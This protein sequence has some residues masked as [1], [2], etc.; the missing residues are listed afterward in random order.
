MIRPGVTV[1]LCRSGQGGESFVLCRSEDR[2]VKEAAIHERFSKRIEDRLESLEKRLRKAKKAADRDKVAVQIGRILGQNSRAA[3]KYKVRIRED[4]GR[5]SG[6]AV[7]WTTKSDWTEWASLT[8]GMY[9]LRTSL[10]PSEW[11]AEDLWTSY[12]QLTDAEAA[13]RTHKHDLA[14]RPV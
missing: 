1:K 10:D 9:A 12:M 7:R 8:E 6:L 2:R 14:L 11:S 13:F 5:A 3:G 4:A